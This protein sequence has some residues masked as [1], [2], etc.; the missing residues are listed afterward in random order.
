MPVRARALALAVLVAA[1]AVL[2]AVPVL[3]PTPVAAAAPKVAIIVGPVG[4][5]TSSY[6]TSANRVADAAIAAGATVVKAYSPKATWAKVRTAVEGASVIVYFGHGNGYPNPYTQGT[7]YTDRVNGFGL[8]RTTQNGDS[9]NW[10]TTMVYCGEKALLGTL[11]SSDGAAQRQY[12]GY[13]NSDGISPAPGFTMVYAQAHYAPGFG[14]RYQE[15]DPLPTMSEGRQRVK[16]YSTPTL[17]LGGGGF[18]ATAYSDA[19][20]IVTRVLTQPDSTYG[21]VFKAGDGYAEPK[22]DVTSHADVPGAKVWVQKT[23][24]PGFHFGDPDFWYAFAGDPGRRIGGGDGLPFDDIAGSAFVDEIVWMAEEGITT[25]CAP[26]LFC[27]TD[28]VTRGQMATFLARGLG[29]P[30]TSTDY[31]ADDDG[32]AH[33]DSINRIVEAGI[34]TGCSETDFC[35]TDQVTRA[36]MASFLANG[37][38]LPWTAIDY[39]N[40]DD[41]NVHE[42]AINSIAEAGITT[43]CRPE[44]LLSRRHPHPSAGGRVP[45]PRDR[46]LRSAHPSVLFRTGP[47]RHRLPRMLTR[48]RS[49]LAALLAIVSIVTSISPAAATDPTE[50]PAPSTAPE[51]SSRTVHAE[52]LAEHAEDA[53]DFTP[54]GTPA[55]LGSSTTGG[56]VTSDGQGAIA[57]LP[58][59]LRREVFGYLPYWAVTASQLQNLKYG[60]VSTIAYFSVGARANGTLAKTSGGASTTGWAG[61]T[62]AAMTDVISKA[63]ARGVKVVLTVTMMAWD[64]DYADFRTLLGSSANRSRLATEIAKAVKARNADGVNLDFEP[65]PD[66]LETQYTALVRRVRAELERLG[67]GSY[68]TVAATGGAAS[69]NEGYELVDNGDSNSHSLVSAGGA[70]AI[71]VMAYDF[72]WS[73]SRRAGGVAPIDSPYILDSREAM[74]AYV[75]KVP[76]N[77]LIWGVPYYGRAWTTTGSALNGVTCASAGTCTAASWASAYVDARK[78]AAERGRLWDGVGQVPW[79]R[80]VSTTYGTHVQGYYDDSRSLGVKYDLVKAR[81]LRGVGIWHLLMDGSRTELWS[82]LAAEFQGLPF[83]DIADSPFVDEIVWLADQGLISGCSATD[84]CPTNRIRRGQMATVLARALRLPSTSADYFTD[85][86]DTAHEGAINRIAAA[87]ITTGCGGDRFCPTELVTRGQLASFLARGLG[88]PATSTDYFGDDEASAHEGAINR[89]AAAGISAGCRPGAF[90]P[91]GLVIRQ[92]MAA[93][94]Y[95]A[96]AP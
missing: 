6:R 81:D 80:Y 94:L 9:D 62:S 76:A 29:L 34:T 61:W 49:T 24:I 55:P 41:A 47:H 32:T 89:I 16:N 60:L 28:Q 78:A 20:E 68:L 86:D 3:R 33:E 58:N 56:A 27:P 2:G 54:G 18:I 64:Y 63:H 31:F 12:C 77:Q 96:L 73:G 85:D 5:L 44:R 52:M 51:T 8:N 79:Y 13:P 59:H 14:E 67:A 39:F 19:H 95:R 82:R 36:Q 10:S 70:H 40:D 84:F 22:L 50:S 90:C 72:N 92:A 83:A 30:A 17:K 46:A 11:T 91:N 26:D 71:M 69:W 25:G 35:P 37:L 4:S 1:S 42:D 74:S 48:R 15:S 23:V 66:S 65:M 57:G 43:G 88:L 75:A 7:E 87:G 38:D 93:F 53:V 45:V 21:Q